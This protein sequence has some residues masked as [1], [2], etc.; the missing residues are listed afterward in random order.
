MSSMILKKL[1]ISDNELG[2]ASLRQYFEN[3]GSNYNVTISLWWHGRGVC[4]TECC[5]CSWL[6]VECICATVVC[7]TL[8]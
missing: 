7:A 4:C 3:A 2:K 5:C 8:C 1:L 6:S